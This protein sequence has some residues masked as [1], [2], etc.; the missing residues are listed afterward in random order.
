MV[1]SIFACMLF[2]VISGLS[3]AAWAGDFQESG[4][5]T[6]MSDY[7]GPQDTPMEWR[8]DSIAILRQPYVE[9]AKRTYSQAKARFRSGLPAGYTFLVTIDLHENNV[10]ENA[11]M[12]VR[13]IS[14]GKITAVLVTKLIRVKS[15][16]Y[17]MQCVFPESMVV[18]WTIISPDGKEEGNF[19]GKF[20]DEY[21]KTHP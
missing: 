17:G 16:Q 11:Y 10:N 2:M 19:V 9:E 13:K 12:A 3:Q 6:G 20:L 21:Y 4:K 8:G 14:D 7:K 15:Y 1:K 18:D 5:D